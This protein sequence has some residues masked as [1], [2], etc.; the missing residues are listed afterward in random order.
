MTHLKIL[1]VNDF[2][3][4]A[5]TLQKYSNIQVD[6]IYM[7]KQSVLSVAKNPL[8]F[9]KGK[10][11][12]SQINQIKQL[13]KEYDVFLCFGWIA[14][15]ICYLAEVN[16][17]MYFVDSYIDP[18]NRIRS[19]ISFVKK[20]LLNNV[21][22]DTL[23]NASIVIAGI[24]HDAKILQKYRPDVKI[25]FPLIDSEMFNPD[26]NR[27]ELK[28]DKFVFLSPQRIESDKGQH[29]LWKAV[30]LTKSDFIVLQTDWGSGEY[31]EKM[32]QIKP[33]KIEI[34]PRIARHDMPSYLVSI[35]ALLGQ[36][37]MTTCGSSEREAALCNK[38]VFC[39]SPENYSVDND[40]PF[41]KESREP[42]DIAAY[43]D[44]MVLDKDFRE[45]LTMSQNAWVKKTFNTN[46][47][48]QEWKEIFEQAAKMKPTYHV[49]TKYRII[50]KM[51]SI[52]E[53]LIHRDLSS[54]GR[55]IK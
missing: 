45:N 18:E 5:F 54:I 6:V 4:V 17:M 40:D 41:Y 35:D 12:H 25:I 31:Y 33:S 21:Y 44:K 15:S 37:S 8:F 23:D 47:I 29:I 3:N 16:Y 2:A 10:G 49:K 30:E 53:N 19:K 27:R 55:N 14:A 36:I 42:K 51:I 24:S 50:F 9:I 43:I 20:N 1:V 13:S 39:Y 46:R 7:H 28:S 34:I 38:P 48:V 52:V 22:K 11:L 26:V 32:L